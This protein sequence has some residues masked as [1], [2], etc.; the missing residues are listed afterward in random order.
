MPALPRVLST[1]PSGGA[2]ED[3]L[4]EKQLGT[5]EVEVDS[6]VRYVAAERSIRVTSGRRPGC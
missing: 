5:I 4:G 2:D 1:P 6:R 3:V